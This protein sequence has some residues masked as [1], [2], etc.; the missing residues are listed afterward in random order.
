[1]KLFFLGHQSNDL[2]QVF[3]NGRARL[4]IG[5]HTQDG[6]GGRLRVQLFGKCVGKVHDSLLLRHRAH[7][8]CAVI[9]IG[10]DHIVDA[11]LRHFFHAGNGALGV[12]LVVKGDDLDVV[13]GAADLDA[14]GFIDPRGACFHRAFVRDILARCRARCHANEA[15]FEYGISGKGQ[16]AQASSNGTNDGAGFQKVTLFHEGNS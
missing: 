7:G 12:F 10:P 3:V 9:D 14:T 16:A 1:M 15:D 6:I 8:S 4:V 13:G 2:H 11:F 5:N